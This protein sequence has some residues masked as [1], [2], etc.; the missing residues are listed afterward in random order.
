MVAYFNSEFF[1]LM[2]VL[3]L[4][5]FMASSRNALTYKMSKK[6]KQN[7]T[8]SLDEIHVTA[9]RASVMTSDYVI[10]NIK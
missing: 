1:L 4:F 7:N 2:T 5:L 6:T 3:H 8:A 10:E 9:K